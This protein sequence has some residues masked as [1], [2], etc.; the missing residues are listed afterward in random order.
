MIVANRILR[1]APLVANQIAAGEVIERPAS[2]VK[3]LVENSIDA[4]ATKI[5]IEIEGGG[6]HKIRVRDNGQ[7]IQ[8]EDLP[9][10]ICRH[11]TSKIRSSDD[12]SKIISL[13][14]RGEALASIVSVARCRVL[15]RAMDQ[16]QAWEMRAE[17]DHAISIL[18]ASHG[19][20]TTIEISDLFFNT[21]VR[22]KF[23]RSEKTES[24][25]IEEWIK[26]MAI[27]FPDVSFRYRLERRA[28]RQ[29]PGAMGAVGNA[30]RLASIVGQSFMKTATEV[31]LK[32]EQYSLHGW[33]G[34]SAL[35]RRQADCQHFFVNQRIVKDRLL[36]SIIRAK[37]HAQGISTE[38]SY[39]AYV[40]FL[41]I[42]PADVDVNVHPT[43]Q[44][45]RFHRTVSVYDFI[46][47][48]IEENQEINKA[49][50]HAR[51][52][53]PVV[54]TAIPFC[55]EVPIP[56]EPRYKIIER[57]D[58]LQIMDA[59]RA[60]EALLCF[61]LKR[62][63]DM[64]METKP[65]LFPKMYALGDPTLPTEEQL[66]GLKKMGFVCQAENGRL[67]IWQQPIFLAEVLSETT[68]NALLHKHWVHEKVAVQL[69]P[70]CALEVLT[71]LEW[72]ETEWKAIPSVWISHKVIEKAHECNITQI[73]N[74]CETH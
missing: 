47:Q 43:K 67:T 30:A 60:K 51:C 35:L 70:F 42:D 63:E 52:R 13:G 39:P 34:S 11:A 5:E 50:T 37:Y 2:V 41:T 44:E 33:I 28:W 29:Y 71:A 55:H 15:S 19:V 62:T 53:S 48:G 17:A 25:V 69:A 68:V 8:K 61:L 40:L 72:A 26:R 22:R 66:T 18:P 21:P 38:G 16:E 54:S 56:S 20:G 12:L 24:L 32:S 74:L 4:Q 45:V 14:F 64:S 57:Q 1:L 3:E 58:G 59:Q 9:L 10:A 65:L 6:V 73:D 31:M 46:R 36:N 7:G 49:V 23:L 27:A